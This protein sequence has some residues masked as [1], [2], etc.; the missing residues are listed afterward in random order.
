[1]TKEHWR[2]VQML[3]EDIESEFEYMDSNDIK[4]VVDNIR[5]YANS[6][7]CVCEDDYCDANDWPVGY[8]E[9][10]PML[11]DGNSLSVGDM[12]RLK[13]HIQAWKE[14]N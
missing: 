7:Y 5:S 2:Q 6:I 8:E 13:E 12:N 14:G 9:I 11:P 4:T 10:F 3:L 1:M